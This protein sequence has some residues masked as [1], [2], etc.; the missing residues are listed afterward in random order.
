MAGPVSWNYMDASHSALRH[1]ALR[2]SA[3]LVVD[4]QCGF[5]TLC[6]DELPVPGALEIVP[7]IN[8]LLAIRSANQ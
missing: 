1:S 5:T 6:P 4:V 3:L 2:H 8:R 7:A